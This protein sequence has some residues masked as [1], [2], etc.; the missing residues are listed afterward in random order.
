M[1]KLHGTDGS[2]DS[3]LSM[4]AKEEFY[5]MSCQV[6]VDKV[7]ASDETF[8]T[9]FKKPSYRKR[10]ICAFLVMFGSESTGILVLYSESIYA[11]SKILA[12]FR[13]TT[14]SYST[15]DSDCLGA[16]LSSSRQST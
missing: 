6:R 13:Q 1:K 11:R 8:M 14:V 5:Q 2:D 12:D 3:P 16:P 4:F 15:L 7:T 9:L 10:M